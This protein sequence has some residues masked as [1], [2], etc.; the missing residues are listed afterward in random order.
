M[1]FILTDDSVFMPK[2]AI[3]RISRKFSRV[4]FYNIEVTG[5]ICHVYL[6]KIEDDHHTMFSEAWDEHTMHIELFI[7]H[8]PKSWI[9][10]FP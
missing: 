8:I 1:N 6:L 7:L 3:K 10:R 5:I 9:L 4:R 2:I